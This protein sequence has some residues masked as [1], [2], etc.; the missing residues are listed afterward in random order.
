VLRKLLKS[1]QIIIL[2]R[3]KSVSRFSA[4]GQS[5]GI[6]TFPQQITCSCNKWFLEAYYP[7]MGS[8]LRSAMG[9]QTSNKLKE[10]TEMNTDHVVRAWKDSKYRLNLSPSERSLLPQHPSGG[11]ALG[12][13]QLLRVANRFF[14]SVTNPNACQTSPRTSCI[15]GIPFPC[16]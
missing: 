1:R 15:N 6:V 11:I 3:D 7:P 4:E 2:A 9:T 16:P 8:F 5:D 10:E 12:E 14:S 13:E